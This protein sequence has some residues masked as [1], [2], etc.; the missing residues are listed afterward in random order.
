MSLRCGCPNDGDDIVFGPNHRCA[1]GIRVIS[2]TPPPVEGVAAD[3]L[4]HELD[5]LERP[6]ERVLGPDELED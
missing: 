1:P 3:N 6:Y 2:C 5:R 4:Q